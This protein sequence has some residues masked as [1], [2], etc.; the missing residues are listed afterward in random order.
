MKMEK[1]QHV[2]CFMRNS[3]ILE[4]IIEDWALAEVILKSLD[5]KNIIIV[6]RPTEDI[7]LT[8]IILQED[9]VNALSTKI[10][11]TKQEIREK[12]QEVL[13]PTGDVENDKLNLKQLRRLVKEQEKQMI[14]NKKKEH[15]GTPNNAKRAVDYS[16][17]NK[18]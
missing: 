9:T 4:G 5:G 13:Q 2:K 15:F 3:M 11:E 6:H 14:A 16:N 8:K 7:L 1:G 12:L 18:Y 10:S 17:P